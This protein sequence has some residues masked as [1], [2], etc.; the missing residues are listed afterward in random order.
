LALLARALP[1]SERTSLLREARRL[2]EKAD[3]L[4]SG[5][6]RESL[7]F[8]RSAQVRHRWELPAFW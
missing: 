5:A 3:V 7:R 6:K 8:H 1:F 4:S 2:V